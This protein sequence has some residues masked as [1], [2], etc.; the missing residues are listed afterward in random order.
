MLILSPLN[1]DIN[2]ADMSSY[3]LT[4]PL[5]TRFILCNDYIWLREKVKAIFS[6]EVSIK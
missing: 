3:F 6:D 2:Q 5:Q 4:V 1:P